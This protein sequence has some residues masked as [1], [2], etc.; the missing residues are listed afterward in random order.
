MARGNKKKILPSKP[1]APYTNRSEAEILE[2]MDVFIEAYRQ[3]CNIRHSCYAAGLE[4]HTY[5]R[6]LKRY[7]EF[8]ERVELARQEA[9]DLLEAT[10]WERA[11]KGADKVVTF[12]GQITDRYKEA[13]DR[14]LEFLLSGH[15]GE[16]FK[17]NISQELTGK[18]GGPIATTSVDLSKLSDEELQQVKSLL[19]KA[20]I[21]L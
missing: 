8:A 17:K 14:L 4:R 1:P 21:D 5:H 6:W 7:P 19:G 2:C 3:N 9:V 18:N 13:S 12:Q 16:R 15:R 20:G 11:T 10:A